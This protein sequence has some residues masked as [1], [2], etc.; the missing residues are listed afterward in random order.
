[1][2]LLWSLLVLLFFSLLASCRLVQNLLGNCPEFFLE[3]PNGRVT[4]TNLPGEN[5]KR[6]CQDYRGDDRFATYYD[7][8]WHIPVWSAYRFRETGEVNRAGIPWRIEPE[9]NHDHQASYADYN[10][11]GED[12]DRGHLYPVQHTATQVDC[13]ATFA[14]TNAIPQDRG[15]NRGQWNVLEGRLSVIITNYCLNR[16]YR[17]YVVVGAVP[18]NNQNDD[19]NNLNIP[20]HIWSAYCCIDNRDNAQL[21]RGFIVANIGNITPREMTVLDLEDELSDLY[22]YNFQV[23]GGRC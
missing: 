23:F 18:D 4:P 8:N 17:A 5:Y 13:N 14:L 2:K 7:T 16:G 1:M 19:I 6:I 22:Q 20:T 21:S 12:W 15:L 10:R 3:M 11:L 9:L